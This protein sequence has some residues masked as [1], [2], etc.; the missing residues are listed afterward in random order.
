MRVREIDGAWV[1]DSV[2]GL[3]LSFSPLASTE[4]HSTAIF[5]G[6]PILSTTIYN[7][8]NLIKECTNSTFSF[9]C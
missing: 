2:G 3:S 7:I 5:G 4:P 8:T 6:L 9:H 1:S